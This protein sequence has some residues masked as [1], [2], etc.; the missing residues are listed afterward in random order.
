MLD[1]LSITGPIYV[2]IALGY[3]SVRLRLFRPDDLRTLGRFVLHFALPALLFNALARSPVASILDPAYLAAY[4]ASGGAVMLGAF[5]WERRVRRRDAPTSAIIATGMSF[6]NLAFVGYPIIVPL[7]GAAGAVAVA[8]SFVVDNLLIMSLSLA[9]AGSGGAAVESRARA[10][11]RALAATGRN[12]MIVAIVAGFL[13]ALAGV[14]L[15]APVT[16]TI[17]LFA[18]ASTAVALFVVGGSLVGLEVRGMVRDVSAIA[19]GKLFVHPLVAAGFAMLV[20]LDPAMRIACIACACMPM[21]SIYP[22]LAQKYRLEGLAAAALL[23][24]TVASFVTI[25]AVLGLLGAPR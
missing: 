3:L 18:G 25:N 21:V 12:P 24:T 9:L 16:R 2:V 20:P 23:V 22:I 15:P 4:A 8:I 6:P 10:L 14:T 19:I 11:A 1:V 13:V 17:D 5:L 7:L